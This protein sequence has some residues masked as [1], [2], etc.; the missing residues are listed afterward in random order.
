[1]PRRCTTRSVLLA[2]PLLCLA[3]GAAAR[4]A[5]SPALHDLAAGGPARGLALR[6]EPDGR[7]VI[8]LFVVGAVPDA[9]L[10]ALGAVIGT[11]L[12]DGTRTLSVPVER[13]AELRA[14]PGLARVAAAYRCIPSNDISVPTT[15]ATPGYWQPAGGGAFNGNAGAGVVVGAVDSGIDWTHDDFKTPAG[16]TRIRYLWDQRT[17]GAPP[18][19]FAYGTEWNAAQIDAGACTQHDVN[20]HGTHVM[21]TAAGN[22]RG[23]G[24]GQP[25]GTFAGMAPGADI[26]MVATD[27]SAAHVVDGVDYIFRKAAALGKPAVVNLSLGMQYGAH[28]GSDLFDSA[29]SALTGPGRILAC[30]AGNEGGSGRHAMAMVPMGAPRT[31]T[32][33]I[34]VYSSNAGPYNDA[35][36]IDA[37]YSGAANMSVTVT[38]PGTPVM[39]VG[40]VV[41]G[42]VAVNAASLSG[43]IYVENG[44]T[45]T[46]GGDQNV[47]IEI[48]DANPARPP[49]NGTWTITLTPVSTTPTTRFD[50]WIAGYQLGGYGDAP[51]FVAGRDDHGLIGS[52]GTALEAI[53]V[54]AYIT[55]VDWP[56][57][58]GFL[59][60]FVD[61]TGLGEL[62]GFSNMG[63]LRN[64]VMKPDIAGPG[65][66]IVSTLSAF[67]SPA[68]EA[69]LI[70]PDGRHVTEAGTSMATPHVAGACALLLA[71]D[72]QLTPDQVKARLHAEAAVDAQT[73]VVP[74]PAW[75]WGKLRLATP[76]AAP[77]G[78]AEGSA[79]PSPA[80]LRQ[81]SPNPFH[82]TTRIAFDLPA[83]GRARL[84][85]L[86]T[87]G[88]LVRVLAD[89]SFP[90]G[91]AELTWDGRT[92]DGAPAA[93]GL[94]FYRLE[95]AGGVEAR[96]MVLSH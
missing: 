1:M 88:R 21:G 86:S 82:P 3:A 71:V 5:V 24:N 64:G 72:P 73:G 78:V 23:T 87:A 19:G 66:A 96:R 12:P 53:T 45:P 91:P 52:P 38:G 90:R 32:F 20:G 37:Y 54:G 34:P 50:A 42:T 9:A 25:A 77:S 36:D 14:L 47:F 16:K 68:P 8:D 63:P 74:N 93:S 59:H 81:N 56:A 80:L 46:D 94:Y 11:R 61:Y 48:Y 22:G 6:V 30:A 60:H 79:P 85:I 2:F 55:K 65:T 76:A 89:R 39:T 18:D 51:V 13:L 69:A 83:A 35:I 7:R 15:N 58:D 75:G 43:Y 49:R 92:A 26:V 27:F 41:K 40:P 33:D 62:A 31:I 44:Y 67:A 10:E 28:D 84:T 17:A 70:S 4:P 29:L 57:L 95:T